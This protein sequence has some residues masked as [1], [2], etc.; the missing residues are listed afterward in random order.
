MEVDYPDYYDKKAKELQQPT[1]QQAKPNFK[2][3]SILGCF[4]SKTSKEQPKN[5]NQ[6]PCRTPV[7]KRIGEQLWQPELVEMY[8]P[9]LSDCSNTDT[10]E[11]AIGAVQNLTACEWQPSAQF[12]EQMRK[13]RGLPTIVELLGLE[14]ADNVVCGAAIA[15][16]NLALDNS[17]KVLI[18]KYAIQQLVMKLPRADGNHSD[19]SR[20]SEETVRA[21]LATLH[22]VFKDRDADS[23]EHASTLVN[24]SDGLQRI[25]HIA[26][27]RKKYMAKT[28]RSAHQLLTALWR[29]TSLR[30]TY[31]NKG[32]K[33]SDFLSKTMMP[34][35]GGANTGTMSVTSTLTRPR[36]ELPSN[37]NTI[38]RS[39][40]AFRDDRSDEKPLDTNGGYPTFSSNNGT[41]PI[42]QSAYPSQ[43]EDQLFQQ[44]ANSY[45]NP[46]ANNYGG[47][48]R[49]QDGG[50]YSQHAAPENFNYPSQGSNGSY[51][52]PSYRQ[53]SSYDPNY[54][55]G[56]TYPNDQHA[57][58][59]YLGEQF[60]NDRVNMDHYSN[61]P[62]NHSS[63]NISQ[64]REGLIPSGDQND[65]QQTEHIY[66]RVNKRKPGNGTNQSFHNPNYN[67]T[68]AM[69][70][71]S[72]TDRGNYS[73]QSPAPV[74]NSNG[75]D[76]WV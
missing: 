64:S 75:V 42:R 13:M 61:H 5:I 71:E 48:Y 58:E 57:G 63:H 10:L 31:R 56:Q 72:L 11:A 44:P 46:I 35:S 17:N 19:H 3:N 9:L 41:L 59:Q 66:A 37:T 16:R 20:A 70:M 55:S 36:S 39:N 4:G 50:S 21:V 8:L 49:Y 74:D 25:L 30:D 73:Y 34:R 27:S 51:R 2:D 38:A 23:C 45:N 69:S 24:D 65:E 76:S 32:Y 60:P 29:F 22:E 28:L 7:G 40:V 67:H 18:G 54:P 6:Y 53:Q 26:K 47:S 52:Q 43:Q 1:K 68:N 15:L 62:L 12:R 33:E 14:E